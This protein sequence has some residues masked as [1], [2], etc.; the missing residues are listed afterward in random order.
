MM[1]S[2]RRGSYYLKEFRLVSALL[3]AAQIEPSSSNG[4]RAKKWKDPQTEHAGHFADVMHK[5]IF[6]QVCSMQ[7]SKEG[8]AYTLKVGRLNE[9]LD[10]LAHEGKHEDKAIVLPFKAMQGR[11]F[12][13][14][15]KLDGERIQLHRRDGRMWYMSRRAI[16]HGPRSLFNLMD[17]V[18]AQQ[19]ASTECI[20]DGE[21]IVWN[22]ARQVFEPFV[23]PA[24]LSPPG[25]KTPLQDPG[26]LEIVY[27][28]FDILYINQL[29]VI[30]LTLRERH[31]LLSEAIKPAP[32]DGIP[33]GDGTF[34]GRI[35]ALT[36]GA[37]L[38]SGA[39]ASKN[40][41]S[42]ADIQ[43]MFAEAVRVEEEGIVI[44][45]LDSP[46]A[47]NDRSSNWLKIKPDYA[48]GIEIDCLILGASYGEGRRSARGSN[49]KIIVSEF[50]VALG[51]PAKPE[52]PIESFIS[53]AKV[54]S[55][56]TDEEREQL[57][58]RLM[59]ILRKNSGPGSEPKQCQVTRKAAARPDLWVT[60][61]RK[62]VVLQ[63]IGDA[64]LIECRDFASRNSLRFPRITA[65]RFHD[66]DWSTITTEDELDK[67]KVQHSE[68]PAQGDKKGLVKRLGGELHQ[69]WSPE[70]YL[71]LGS[72]RNG[73]KFDA[74]G[75]TY[76]TEID[77]RDMEAILNRHARL[78][79]ARDFLQDEL[80]GQQR[81]GGS[82]ESTSNLLGAADAP[83]WCRGGGTAL[84][85]V[86]M[87][88]LL[89]KL[90]IVS[91]SWVEACLS[92]PGNASRPASADFAVSIAFGTADDRFA[93]G[94]PYRIESWPW[95][96]FELI[97]QESQQKAE[98]S[99]AAHIV[100]KQLRGLAPEPMADG[101]SL[102]LDL[103]SLRQRLGKAAKHVM[104]DRND[105]GTTF[106]KKSAHVP[107]MA[108]QANLRH[109][110]QQQAS[111]SFFGQAAPQSV[112][113][114]EV[115][116]SRDA[117]QA[118][119]PP[120]QASM[121]DQADV[122]G[123]GAAHVPAVKSDSSQQACQG[124]PGSQAIEEMDPFLA[125]ILRGSI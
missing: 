71:L 109:K 49:G 2:G 59:P 57:S 93:T 28:A 76:S 111:R 106:E 31:S 21:L 116:G 79:T 4:Q 67:M 61:P 11:P 96:D 108:S 8:E 40:G 46:W 25:G 69:M 70:H 26:K 44:K 124:F 73:D 113:Q 121:S 53:F 117:A 32:D 77:A 62:S 84:S 78:S 30:N 90:Q 48:F 103:P 5:Y 101:K 99:K 38:P 110:Q 3:L 17:E 34:R 75:D 120:P 68:G 58:E 16:D 105:G 65:V 125:A 13:T 50:L 43:E 112:W 18:V 92:K 6:R 118:R 98:S 123:F 39:V 83:P 72:S 47:C 56:L 95:E 15:T 107:A 42:L 91:S 97:K 80:W 64:R 100:K 12:V 63:V 20:L 9:L 104:D 1:D 66:K 82:T 33:I 35:I 27:V 114:Q 86:R 23:A 19:V 74:F 41:D 54:A 36:P 24:K 115:G 60:D 45:A 55:G 10:Q 52:G 22:R 94:P 119:K 14:E 89:E 88:L 87:G 85:N 122:A 37:T 7:A 102:K 51:V 81:G 29:S